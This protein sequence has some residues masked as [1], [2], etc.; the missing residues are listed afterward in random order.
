VFMVHVL[1]TNKETGS[2]MSGKLLLVD[3]AGSEKIRKSGA[4]GQQLE[5]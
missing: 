3:L 2:K 4:A 1:Q 5:V